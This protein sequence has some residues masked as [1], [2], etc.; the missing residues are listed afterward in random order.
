MRATIHGWKRA[1]LLQS[2]SVKSAKKTRTLRVFFVCGCC[3]VSASLADAHHLR[4]LEALVLPAARAVTA[5]EELAVTAVAVVVSAAV[6][7]QA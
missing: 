4:A 7:A 2:E 1:S 5:V 3:D 6:A